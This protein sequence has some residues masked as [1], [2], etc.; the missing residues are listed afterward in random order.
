MVWTGSGGISVS[1]NASVRNAGAVDAQGGNHFVFDGRPGDTPQVVNDG[2]F[3]VSGTVIFDSGVTFSNR[4]TVNG[5]VMNAGLLSGSGTINGSVINA[6]Q[7]SPGDAA[8]TGILT[9]KGDYTQT[10]TGV[11][12]IRIGGTD[13]GSGYDQLLVAG[14]ATLDG[15][16]NVSLI[17]SFV[18]TSGSRFQ[19]MLFSSITG[20]FAN[21]NID[22]IFMLAYGSTDITLKAT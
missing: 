13:P 21:A 19:I 5:N 8:T 17:N 11:L 12:N 22:P 18:P 16:L 1:G 10:A 20:A 9:I 7:V 15:T 2:V 4:G 6:G 3:T 14:Q